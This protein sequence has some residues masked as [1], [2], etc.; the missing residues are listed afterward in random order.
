MQKEEGLLQTT[1]ICG[2]YK[3]VKI[4]EPSSPPPTTP[5][6]RGGA[7]TYENPSTKSK[8]VIIFL[9]KEDLGVKNK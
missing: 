9:T 1:I 4:I 5:R 8:I 7:E 3:V 2:C 6:G